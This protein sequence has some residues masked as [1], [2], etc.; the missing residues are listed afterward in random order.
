MFNLE[1]EEQQNLPDLKQGESYICQAVQLKQ[2]KTTPHFAVKRG[3][4]KSEGTK[5]T[6]C[7]PFDVI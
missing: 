1:E 5:L 2:M 4:F 3:S 6:S 7:I